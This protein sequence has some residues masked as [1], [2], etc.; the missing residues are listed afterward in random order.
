LILAMIEVGFPSLRARHGPAEF[1][2][3]TRE[4]VSLLGQE[5][6]IV[7]RLHPSLVPDLNEVLA[8]LEPER[9]AA[10]LVEPR[11]TLPIGDARIA[12]R[13]GMATRDT[14]AL[15]ARLAEVL[16]PLGLTS[17]AAGSAAA[18]SHTR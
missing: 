4:V 8:S 16:A 18:H 13:H 15:L 17:E 7:I 6:R 11:D 14:T 12:W 5:P 3:F 2:R 9:R 10:V 1:V